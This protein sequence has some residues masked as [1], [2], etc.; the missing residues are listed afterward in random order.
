MSHEA[1]HV[2]VD[3]ATSTMPTWL[4]EGFADYVALA[5]SDLP[6]AVTA[7]QILAKV[8]QEGP[9]RTLPGV[10]DFDPANKLLGTSYEA[11]WL[12]CRLLAEQYGEKR[13]VAFYDAVDAGAAPERAFVDLGTTE[14]AFTQRWRGY[15]RELAG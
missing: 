6:V 8:R 12:A 15:L 10:D 14:E 4:L 9:P 13:L 11:A 7:S 3:A 2:A 5:R 1:T